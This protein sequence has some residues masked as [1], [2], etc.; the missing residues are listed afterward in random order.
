MPGRE[1]HFPHLEGLP[2]AV[3]DSVRGT[4]DRRPGS[5]RRTSTID[6]VWPGGLG[7]PLQLVGRSRDL[8]TPLRG[9]PRVVGEASMLVGLARYRT[10]TSIEV[11]PEREGVEGLVGT[12]GGS[13]L[14]AAIDRAL[15]G[16]R[17]A[18]TP[19][20]LL[21]DD[22]AG[23]S[24]ISNFVWTRAEPELL[25]RMRR[26]AA[27]SGGPL[28]PGFGVRKG[29]VVCSGLRPDGWAQTHWKHEMSPGHTVVPAGDIRSPDD[30]LAWHEFPPDPELGMRRHRRIDVWRDGDVL[31]VD[32]FFR[33]ACWEPDGSQIALHE[34]SVLAEIDASSL[35]LTSVEA[36]PRALPFPECQWA[37]PHAEGLLGM[38]VS[39]FRTSVQ[40]TLTELR[41][42]THLNDM[43]RCLAEIPAL[44]ASI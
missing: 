44:V 19:L 6:M 39:E 32:A 35:T 14:R 37:A 38:P 40:E 43:L 24:L 28:S 31:R 13:E 36:T 18:A 9:E 17:A 34:Y 21:L 33:D 4:P 29:R 30:P 11:T 22:I 12:V 41:A 2:P 25:E 1:S 3:D 27:S 15:P 16:E 42:C 7:T 10:V 26:E 20:H 23:T 8:L 5:V